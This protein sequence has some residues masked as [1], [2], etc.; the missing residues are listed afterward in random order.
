METAAPFPRAAVL[1]LALAGCAPAAPRP[2]EPDGPAFAPEQW[3]QGRTEGQGE[4]RRVVGGVQSRFTMVIEGGWDGQ[5]LTMDETFI[6]PEGRWNRLWTITKLENGRYS[7]RLTTGHGPAEITAAGDTVR[8]RY[9]ADAPLL[10][11]PFTARF[12]QTLRLRPDGTV[13]N[14]ADVYK[15]GVRI[16]RSTVVF[17]KAEPA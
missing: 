14:T 7:G 10:H 3:F 8:M 9:R 5:V 17:R 13:L 11:R 4:F 2:G 16:G 12:E 1:C 6:A 15:W